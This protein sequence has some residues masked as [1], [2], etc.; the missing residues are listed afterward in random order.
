MCLH[1]QLC[2]APGAKQRSFLFKWPVYLWERAVSQKPVF[3]C[4]PGGAAE[5]ALIVGKTCWHIY[6]C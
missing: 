3:P 6:A 2:V 4:V 5:V 1:A